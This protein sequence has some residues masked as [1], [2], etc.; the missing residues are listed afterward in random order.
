MW[1]PYGASPFVLL[2][3]IFPSVSFERLS[4]SCVYLL[5]YLVHVW[6]H[7]FVLT[8]DASSFCFGCIVEVEL[9]LMIAQPIHYQHQDLRLVRVAL[10]I[11]CQDG[12]ETAVVIV[13][14]SMR[15]NESVTLDEHKFE[16]V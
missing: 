9:H 3:E 11:L 5:E 12:A 7:Y 16:I 10:Q 14:L 8:H 15:G 6:S 13:P 2:F 4:V 1:K